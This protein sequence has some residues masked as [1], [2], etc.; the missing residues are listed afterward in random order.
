[1]KLQRLHF[2]MVRRGLELVDLVG[3]VWSDRSSWRAFNAGG[4]RMADD[5]GGNELDV[6]VASEVARVTA[7]KL[8]GNVS[9]VTAEAD[10]TGTGEGTGDGDGDGLRESVRL[11]EEA[12]E[13]ALRL[14]SSIAKR[15]CVKDGPPFNP[16]LKHQ[17]N[18]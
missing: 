7:D 11:D 10:G 3:D 14:I 16:N 12:A 4:C 8:K 13:M 6:I 18:E 9:I 17:L 2:Q 1:M 5:G 15:P